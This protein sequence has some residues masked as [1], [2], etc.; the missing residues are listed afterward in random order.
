MEIRLVN[1]MSRE[2]VLKAYVDQVRNLNPCSTP[3]SVFLMIS[4]MPT[5]SLFEKVT[6]ISLSATVMVCVSGE[7]Y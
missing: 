6:V 1:T 4:I 3:S 2:Y 5:F 7:Q